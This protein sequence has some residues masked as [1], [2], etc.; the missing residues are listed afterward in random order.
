MPEYNTTLYVQI[1]VEFPFKNILI[2]KNLNACFI[3]GKAI[4]YHFWSFHIPDKCCPSVS[5]RK[6]TAMSE[7]KR[8]NQ[9]ARLQQAKII[10]ISSANKIIT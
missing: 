4:A 8:T 5:I 6:M 9:L 1:R 10:E 2:M 7:K 3:Y